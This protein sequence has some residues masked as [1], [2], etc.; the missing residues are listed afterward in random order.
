MPKKRIPLPKVD[1]YREDQWRCQSWCLK[2]GVKIYHLPKRYN[3]NGFY[4]AVES[5]GNITKSIKYDTI[6][7]ASYKI[8]E[9]YCYI[10]DKYNK[11][12]T[13]AI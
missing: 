9:L 3:A 7:E 12:S 2:N 11:Q 1:V 13:S 6:S 8:W 10:Y 4:F 5:S